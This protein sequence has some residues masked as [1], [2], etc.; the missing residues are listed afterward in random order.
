M[1]SLHISRNKNPDGVFVG[2]LWRFYYTWGINRM[3][4]KGPELEI[5]HREVVET[6]LARSIVLRMSDFK[7]IHRNG[8]ALH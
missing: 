4:I 5:A 6:N 3:I 7:L 2:L 1:Q 8:S